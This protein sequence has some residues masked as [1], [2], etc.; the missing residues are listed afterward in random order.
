M[1]AFKWLGYLGLVY[2]VLVFLFE[3]VILGYN[4]PSFEDEGGCSEFGQGCGIPMIIITTTD[5]KGQSSDRMLARFN[6]ADGKIYVSAHHWPRSWYKEAV[7]NP[8]VKGTVNGEVTD[9]VAV[10]VEG[11]EFDMVDR[12]FPLRLPVRI[13]MGFPPKRQILR[14]DPIES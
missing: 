2:I 3:T 4:Q 13:M 10:A 8:N 5:D 6:S 14:L 9:Y 1:K 12:G 7:K 11:E